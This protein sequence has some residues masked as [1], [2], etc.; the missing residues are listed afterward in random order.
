MLI[1]SHCHLFHSFS[2]EALSDYLKLH[3]HNFSYLVDISTNVKEFL[4]STAHQL[5]EWIFRAVGL[6]PEQ[7]PLFDQKMREELE[8][9]LSEH[10]AQAIGEIGLDY[11]WDYGTPRQQE[12]LFRY[13]IELA[14]SKKLPLIIHSRDA[15]QDTFNILSSYSFDI[16]VILHCYGYGPEEAVRLGWDGPYYFSFAGNLTYKNAVPLQRTAKIVPLNRIL[17]ETD[18]PYLSPIPHRGKPNQ[19]HLISHTYDFL[20]GL[21]SLERSG[22]EQQIQSN[23]EK[24]FKKK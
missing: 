1:D 12:A 13:Q 17:L 2:T 10:P 4:N 15:F 3:G 9:V 14:I 7:A 18:A 6:Y 24:I 22:L 5:P 21:R 23:F 8:Q 11:H 16:P 19:P 20:C